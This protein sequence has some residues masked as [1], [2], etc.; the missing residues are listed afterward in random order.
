MMF[1][2]FRYAF[3]NLHTRSKVTIEVGASM[4]ATLAETVIFLM[5][6][7]KALDKRV[8]WEG[9]LILYAILFCLFYRF[10]FTFILG[11]LANKQR[12]RKLTA[13]HL[14]MMSY[15]GLRGAVSFAMAASISDKYPVKERI[16][17]ATLSVILVTVFLMGSTVQYIVNWMRFK[18]NLPEDT[19]TS[20]AMERANF[21]LLA[22]METILG[23]GGSTLHYWLERIEQ[24]DKRYI[25][26]LLCQ[27]DYVESFGLIKL[28]EIQQNLKLNE[29]NWEAMKEA[30]KSIKEERDDDDGKSKVSKFKK[31]V[32]MERSSRIHPQPGSDCDEA[33]N[34]KLEAFR[35]LKEVAEESKKAKD[36]KKKTEY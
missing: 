20:I 8:S 23:G 18:E 15:G 13:N 3:K 34:R 31:A 11:W 14:F 7:F 21:H 26:P 32:Q 35:R 27:K 5:L 28:L 12:T 1:L 9:W 4:M 16:I 25:Q 36:L 22:G 17:G 29:M 30:S 33:W 24:F 6:G 10:L 2:Y 19:F